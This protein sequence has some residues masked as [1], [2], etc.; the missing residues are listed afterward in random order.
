M[1]IDIARFERLLADTTAA[2]AQNRGMNGVLDELQQRRARVSGELAAFERAAATRPLARPP[3]L[4]LPSGTVLPPDA[5]PLLDALPQRDAQLAGLRRDLEQIDDD[6]RRATQCQDTA[7]N[8][9]TEL[10]RLERACRE[11]AAANGV[12]L[13]GEPPSPSAARVQPAARGHEFNP[14]ITAAVASQGGGSSPPAASAASLPGHA[15]NPRGI[16]DRLPWRSR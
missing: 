12:M 11:W 2:A 8:R 6:I 14:R 7:W 1:Q 5:A 15:L 10:R 3:K 4:N 9:L 16:L 13:P